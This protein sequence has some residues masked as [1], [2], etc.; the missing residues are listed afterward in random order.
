MSLV[1][2]C[3]L[4]Y[5]SSGQPHFRLAPFPRTGSLREPFDCR[6]K[7]VPRRWPEGGLQLW[8]QQGQPCGLRHAHRCEG[9]QTTCPRGRQRE[10]GRRRA[11]ETHRLGIQ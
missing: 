4:P 3:T 5:L 2:S 8:H 7:I 9:V 11:L 10:V 6:S 1:S